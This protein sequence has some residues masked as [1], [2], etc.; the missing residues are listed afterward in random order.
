MIQHLF[1]ASHP[2]EK[3][4]IKFNHRTNHPNYNLFDFLGIKK[5]QLHS[6]IPDYYDQPETIV[7]YQQNILNLTT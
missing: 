7:N 3:K 4:E 2:Q 5:I 1:V 6:T